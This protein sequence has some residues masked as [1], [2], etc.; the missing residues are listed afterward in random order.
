MLEVVEYKPF[1]KNTLQ[2]FL[3]VR[4]K[5]IGLEIKDVTHHRKGDDVWFN[6][7]SKSYQKDD[8]SNGYR[9]LVKF[10]DQRYNDSFQAELR[11]LVKDF[12]GA[13]HND[14]F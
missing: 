8:G 9:Y 2:G 10:T 11:K 5:S 3:T 1:H 12:K 4:L 13:D 14:I 6:M 7:P